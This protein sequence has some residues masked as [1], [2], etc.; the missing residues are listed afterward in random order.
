MKI[1]NR[2][3]NYFSSPSIEPNGEPRVFLSPVTMG[4]VVARKVIQKELG[5]KDKLSHKKM[6]QVCFDVESEILYLPNS[7]ELSKSE[8]DPLLQAVR[9]KLVNDYNSKASQIIEGSP[10]SSFRLRSIDSFGYIKKSIKEYF[11]D[12]KP[13]DIVEANLKRMP[14]TVAQ[15]PAIYKNN[16]N[17]TG[18][19][20]KPD[21]EITFYDEVD[22][23]GRH[24][25][26]KI[27]I[28]STKEPFILIDIS[29]EV[30]PTQTQKE[31]AILSG[32]RDYLYSK[33]T[34]NKED[35]IFSFAPL[36][37]A[38]RYMY[39]GWSF[40]EI[41]SIFIGCC[42]NFGELIK[43]IGSL[44][45]AAQSL[46]DEGYVNPARIPYHLTFK[47]DPKTFPLRLDSV[48]KDNQIPFF[49]II[50]Y[51]KSTGFILIETPAF[52]DSQLCLKILKAK[53]RP[54]ITRYNPTVEMIDVKSSSGVLKEL[55]FRTN[56]PNKIKDLVATF[57]IN[58][59][60]KD[61]FSGDLEFK[62]DERARAISLSDSR[63]S[64]IRKISDYY[65]A[66]DH[67]KKMCK[68]RNVEFSD[69]QVVIGPL[70]RIFGSGIQ[71]GF[72]GEKE[73][74]KSKLKIPHQI[75]KG[76]YVTPPIM[77]VNSTSMPSYAEQTETLIHEYSHNLFS[78]VNP[79]HEHLYNKKANLRKTD[80]HKYWF[81]Y[82]NDP[83]ERLAHKEE[84][85]YE[86]I[87]GKS[88]DEIVRDKV[89]GSITTDSYL[90]SYPI[91][92]QFKVLVDE[93]VKEIEETEIE[94]K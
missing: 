42:S 39:L 87:S 40:E 76:L 13:I 21:N 8:I 79:E 41:C 33:H 85:R 90:R 67:I 55:E 71:G 16:K 89:G 84:I 82:L 64:N 28:I 54:L 88:V 60:G 48:N 23:K 69:I 12:I 80:H 3:V 65:Y 11:G 86:L 78:K 30:N 36:Y 74:K 56:Q 37:A 26:E 68:R 25:K 43:G 2:I 4:E 20:V 81:L 46:E 92:L 7:N 61:A 63:Y 44:L 75:D 32:Y 50:E 14:S 93:V 1:K 59:L 31:W 83:D 9:K 18:G 51:D 17:F 77:A 53:S 24:R 72:M 94:E 57:I 62:C 70:D 5:Q 15:L 45:Q 6:L 29:P 34:H 10:F 27:R 38:K 73:F 52:I 22:I 66:T 49:K 47:I 19:F 91:A 35:I 58:E